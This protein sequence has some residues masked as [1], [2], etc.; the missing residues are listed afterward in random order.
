MNEIHE[1]IERLTILIDLVPQYLENENEDDFVL[2]PWIGM[3][4]KK[5]L[6]GY[7]IDSAAIAHQRIVRAQY[8]EAP[9]IFYNRKQWIDIQQYNSADS[10]DLIQLWKWYNKHL[11]H[12]IK[13]ISFQNLEKKIWA[14]S[15]N[16]YNLKLL[17]NQY[18]EHMEKDLKQIIGEQF[19]IFDLF[20][21]GR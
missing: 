16:T 6:L 1:A 2:Q 12:I 11:L 15:N 8:E 19:Q 10:Y 20:S 17:I 21:S 18:I 13:N 14:R 9:I 4:S 3:W 7:L 5:Q